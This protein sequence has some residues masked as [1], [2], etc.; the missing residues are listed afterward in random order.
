MVSKKRK[1]Q[2][3]VVL[4]ILFSN[5][6]YELNPGLEYVKP[7]LHKFYLDLLTWVC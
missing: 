7:V 4:L 6:S 1:A 2:H 3:Y 5:V